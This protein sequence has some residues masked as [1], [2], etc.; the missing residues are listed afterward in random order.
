MTLH[1]GEEKPPLEELAHYGTKGMK[2][3]HRKKYSAQEIHD[4]RARQNSRLNEVNN[5]AHKLNLATGK[6]KD[7]AAKQYA[8]LYN[9]L[10]T[11]K[12]AAVAARMTKG[13]KAATLILTGPIGPLIL[14][15]NSSQVKKLEK[16]RTTQ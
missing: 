4:A 15:A 11:N 2:W 1:Y 13:E 10:Q 16:L 5:Q 3:G 14:A 9:D 12:D 7:T 8:K 6:S